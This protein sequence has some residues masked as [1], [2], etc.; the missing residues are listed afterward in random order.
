MNGK[1]DKGR[2][3]EGNQYW[4]LRLKHGRDRIIQ[5]PKELEDNSNEY[6]QWCID[7]P[8]IAFEVHG[9]DAYTIQVPKKRVFQ[10]DGFA[11]ASG[12]ADWR[13]IEELKKVSPDFLQVVT[14]IENIIK[15][16]KFEGAAS[17]FFNSNIV[18]RDLGLSDKSEV[19]VN[20][21]RKAVAD[22]FPLDKTEETTD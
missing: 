9:K 4:N 2:F 6:F 3:V 11:L 15:T 20:D 13:Q 5:S 14:R 22:L 17:G 7:N 19:E 1:D 18:A 16:Q 10:K 8:L 21:N 12:L